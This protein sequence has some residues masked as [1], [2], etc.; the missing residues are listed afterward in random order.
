MNVSVSRQ[1]LDAVEEWLEQVALGSDAE[2]EGRKREEDTAAFCAE[3]L[4]E[5]AEVEGERGAD[6]IVACGGVPVLVEVVLEAESKRMMEAL[7]GACAG[8]LPARK[9]AAIRCLVRIGKVH[10][11]RG[12]VAGSGMLGIVSAA[13][14]GQRSPPSLRALCFETIGVLASDDDAE[15]AA[16]QVLFEFSKE[17]AAAVRAGAL[18]AAAEA[19]GRRDDVGDSMVVIEQRQQV[20][21]HALAN[22]GDEKR[23]EEFKRLR[24]QALQVR[25]L[26]ICRF[27]PAWGSLLRGSL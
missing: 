23:V 21:L 27:I 11:H 20:A 12:A 18:A 22:A 5:F 7:M 9:V 10:R 25:L 24:Q 2:V 4:A 16:T 14:V 13:A 19:G 17:A 1:E 3:R 15:A 26:C 6:I 8:V